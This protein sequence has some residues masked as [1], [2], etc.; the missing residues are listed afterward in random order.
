MKTRPANI[1][2]TLMAFKSVAVPIKW[3]LSVSIRECSRHQ[4]T[5]IA[6]PRWTQ[7]AR[8]HDLRAMASLADGFNPLYQ[9]GRA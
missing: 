4:H 8:G 7:L 9:T 3:R 6:S 5:P 2:R 1:F